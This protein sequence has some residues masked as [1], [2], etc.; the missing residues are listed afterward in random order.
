[1]IALLIR[2]YP[3]RWRARYGLEFA[4]MLEAR[5]LAPFD[6][7]DILLGALDAHLHLRGLAAAPEHSKGFTMTLRIGG[8]AAIAGGLLTLTALVGSQLAPDASVFWIPA[9]FIAI[10]ALLIALVG[11][12]AF[13]ARRHPRLIWAAFVLPAVGAFVS[14]V[15]LIGMAT[16]GDARF[17]ADYSAWYVWSV[18]MLAMFV[19]SALFAIATWRTRTLARPAAAMLAVGALLVIPLLGG[20]EFASFMPEAMAPLVALVAVV[21]F[22]FGWTGLGISALRIDGLSRARLEPTLP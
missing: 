19:G 6:V 11:L 22:T 5:P 20:L 17:I 8:Y 7:A 2:L 16:N 12:S 3:A 1:M 13:Q 4:A 14:L 9:I 10:A 15:G 18:G 21:G